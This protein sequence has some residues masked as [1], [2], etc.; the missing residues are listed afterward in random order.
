M[1]VAMILV[2]GSL[3]LVARIPLFHDVAWVLWAG[4]LVMFIA[5]AV[6]AMNAMQHH[7]Q[8]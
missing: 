3:P 1:L 7:R 8:Q 5:A 4:S 6:V 2:A